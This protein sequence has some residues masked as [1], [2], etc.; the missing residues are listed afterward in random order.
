[1]GSEELAASN[2]RIEYT[3]T[4]RTEAAISSETLVMADQTTQY[5]IHEHYSGNYHHF[6]EKIGSNAKGSDL[7]SGCL[8]RILARTATLTE[9]FCNV[10]KS[11]QINVR[12]ILN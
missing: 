5:G 2:F 3:P 4:L 10:P 12:I 1:L 8:V 9:A 6:T 7:Y 11:L